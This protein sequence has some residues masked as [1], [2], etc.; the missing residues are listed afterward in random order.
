MRCQR[1]DKETDIYIMSWFN[2]QEICMQC[3]EKEQKRIDINKAKQADID[4]CKQGNFNFKG[5]G[6]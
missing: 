4:A 2:T 5:I 3:S 1:C 6:L